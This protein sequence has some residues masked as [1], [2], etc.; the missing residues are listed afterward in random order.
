MTVTRKWL[1]NG[2]WFIAVKDE[3]RLKMIVIEYGCPDSFQDGCPS[4][5]EQDPD[6]YQ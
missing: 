4:I 6:I 5:Y 1:E 2:I 3:K